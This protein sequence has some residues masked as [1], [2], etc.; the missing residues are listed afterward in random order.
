MTLQLGR[1]VR[2][3]SKRV[4]TP[5]GGILLVVF[6]AIQLLIQS[7]VNTM[8]V[9]LFPPGPAGEIEVAL[10]L[11]LPVSGRVAGALFGVA[12]ILSAVYFVVLARGFT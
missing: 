7:S 10:G 6:I 3:G 9:G 1:V 4:L 5:T 12:V 11:T 2:D 8:V